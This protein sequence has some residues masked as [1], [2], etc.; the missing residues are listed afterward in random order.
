[1]LKVNVPESTIDFD[2]FG[3]PKP[4]SFDASVLEDDDA[5]DEGK[6][7]KNVRLIMRQDHTLRVI[8]NTPILPAMDFNLSKKLKSSLI[9]FTAFDGNEAKQVQMK[10][11]LP[12]TDPSG[13]SP[14]LTWHPDERGE[15]HCLHQPDAGYPETATRCLG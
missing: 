3:N 10:V 6:G 9:L 11:G 12:F 7:R 5:E 13:I 8:L 2:D 4:E 1:M 14:L 15:C